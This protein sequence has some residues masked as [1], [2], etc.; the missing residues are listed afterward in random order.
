MEIPDPAGKKTVNDPAK[1]SGLVD[2]AER[3]A[4]IGIEGLAWQDSG[5]MLYDAIR[6]DP[7]ELAESGAIRAIESLEDA[8][9]NYA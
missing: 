7:G 2:K 1:W 9:E 3:N 8:A 5:D 6:N 4:W